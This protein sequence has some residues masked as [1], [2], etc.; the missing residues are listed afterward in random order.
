[1]TELFSIYAV[2]SAIIFIFGAILGIQ[3]STE[4]D[5]FTQ[6]NLQ[7]AVGI[8]V[9]IMW[10]A[11]IAAEITMTSYTASIPVHGLMGAV[12][13]YFFSEDGLSINIGGG[14]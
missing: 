14:E 2:A 13:G 12:V 6:S 4:D 7:I 9:T 3:F 11:S 1:M 10:V 5:I 8:L